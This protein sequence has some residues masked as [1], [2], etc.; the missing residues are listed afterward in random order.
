MIKYVAE[1]YI[2]SIA[3]RCLILRL[4]IGQITVQEPAENKS[5]H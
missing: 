4:P 2:R 1:Y 5:D 3:I